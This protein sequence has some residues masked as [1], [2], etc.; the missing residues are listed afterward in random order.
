MYSV[1]T[2]D[3]SISCSKEFESVIRVIIESRFVLC[4]CTNTHFCTSR[5]QA[6][7]WL[8]YKIKRSGRDHS[9]FLQLMFEFSDSRCIV[10]AHMHAIRTAK[11]T[12]TCTVLLAP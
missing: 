8:T 3:P 10:A 2:R 7:S 12:T 5:T 11:S 6:V 4:A 9:Q 1:V